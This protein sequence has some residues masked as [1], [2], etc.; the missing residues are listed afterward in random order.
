MANLMLWIVGGFL[1]GSIP[2]S[3]LLGRLMTH[4][5]IR[6]IGDGNPGAANA[7]K[8][9]GWTSGLPAMILDIGKGFL[10]VFLAVHIGHLNGL[11]LLP[12]A[13]A[14]ILGHAFSPFLRFKGG[15]AIGVSGGVW[16]AL[17]CFEPIVVFGIFT[18][19]ML[20]FQPEHA[21]C[22]VVGMS[23]LT[24]Y[25]VVTQAP[26][27]IILTAAGNLLII[28]CKHRLELLKPILLRQWVKNL[29]F[30]TRSS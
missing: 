26:L 2:F 21:W 18:L 24:F 7:W 9:G 3:L 10:P 29:L 5:D 20:L 25:W 15:K 12:I 1:S 6:S 30:R 4:K 19:V 11:A 8:A 16:L 17:A 14:P 23:C 28:A 13:L 27:P 22:V